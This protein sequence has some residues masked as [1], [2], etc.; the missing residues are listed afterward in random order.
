[1]AKVNKSALVMHSAEQMYA[2]VNNV[3]D[4]PNFLPWCSGSSIIE[5]SDTELTARLDISKAGFD[6]SF[7]TR[8]EMQAPDRIDLEL[9][10]GPFRTFKGY[11]SFKKLN[12]EA[13]KVTLDL[14]FDFTGK[15]ANFAMGKIFNQIALTMV[16]AFCQQ[17]DIEY[18]VGS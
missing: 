13:C 10:E 18:G 15:V 5:E 2:L 9:V 17:A 11:W 7:T 8:N 14:D 3:R 4:Y 6:Y 1:M 12:D 16:D